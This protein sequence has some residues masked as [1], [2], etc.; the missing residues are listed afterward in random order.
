MIRVTYVGHATVQIETSGVRLLTD[1]VLRERVAHLRRLTPLPALHELDHPDAVLISHAHFDHLDKRSLQLLRACPAIAPRGCAG[2]LRRA[3]FSDVTEA[4]PGEPVQVGEARVHPVAVVHDGRRHPASR[5]RQTLGYVI[6]GAG[7]AFFAGDTDV[8]DAMS[9]VAGGLDV[10]LLPIWG[11]GPRVGRGHMNPE[12][13]ARAVALLR[14][15][16]VIPV[17]W[18]TIAS[19]RAP[20]VGDPERPAREFAQQ[21][22][23]SAPSVEVRILAPGERTEIAARPAGGSEPE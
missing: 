10:A 12:R 14:P 19:P 23:A 20:W 7:R 13:A 6:E 9:R 11:W 16:V 2:L 3:G 21:V 18:G 15:R 22:A 4:R 8:F 1:P 5:A 17:H